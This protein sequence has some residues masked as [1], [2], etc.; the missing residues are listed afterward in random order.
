MPNFT[1]ACDTCEFEDE[2]TLP[3]G[4]VPEERD[5]DSLVAEMLPSGHTER[6]CEGTVSRVWTPVS[7]GAVPGGGG[8]PAR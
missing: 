4:Q 5:C 7:I 2:V 8:S 6:N 3:F 1:I